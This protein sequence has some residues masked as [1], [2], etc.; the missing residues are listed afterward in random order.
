MM[1]SVYLILWKWDWQANK[2]CQS[3][4]LNALLANVWEKRTQ[5]IFGIFKNVKAAV[6]FVHLPGLCLES[7][8]LSWAISKCSC[9]VWVSTCYPLLANVL[10]SLTNHVSLSLA[11]ATNGWLFPLPLTEFCLNNVPKRWLCRYPG[12]VLVMAFC[13]IYR[14]ST[15]K[16]KKRRNGRDEKSEYHLTSLWRIWFRQ[17]DSP[18]IWECGG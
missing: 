13:Q 9:N 4:P 3:I 5:S 11:S 16:E 8:E 10:T 15:N 7:L 12:P 17:R 18:W 2:A 6:S 14:P 1:T